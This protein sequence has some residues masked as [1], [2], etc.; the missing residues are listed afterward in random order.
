PSKG[1]ERF[2]LASVS[3]RLQRDSVIF[4][5]SEC[6][7]W[8]AISATCYRRAPIILLSRQSR[9]HAA[10]PSHR[11]SRTRRSSYTNSTQAATALVDLA[12]SSRIYWHWAA[13]HHTFRQLTPSGCGG[14]A[15][16]KHLMQ[17]WI[18]VQPRSIVSRWASCTPIK[19]SIHN[20]QRS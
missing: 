8:I 6:R 14:P 1:W 13:P 3:V 19:A 17:D 10:L 11:P 16:G 20:L 9:L 18:S 7:A 12:I 4:I 2:V 5:A 15:S